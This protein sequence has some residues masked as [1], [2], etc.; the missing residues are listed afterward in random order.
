MYDPADDPQLRVIRPLGEGGT[1]F[2][3]LAHHTLLNREVAVKYG[4][5]Q[6]SDSTASF[7]KLICREHDLIGGYRFPGLVRPLLPAS[8]EQDHLI[9]ELC[10]GPTLSEV[11][12]IGSVDQALNIISAIA[13]DLEFLRAAGLVHGDLKPTTSFSLRTGRH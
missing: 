4:R 2:V 3:V 11:R 10:P 12:R 7:S 5:A 9:L 13:A 1:A 8:G 6:E